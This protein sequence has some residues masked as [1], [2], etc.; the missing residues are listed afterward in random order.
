MSSLFG[1]TP[2]ANAEHRKRQTL[3]QPAQ[4]SEYLIPGRCPLRIVFAAGKNA[5]PYPPLAP[6]RLHR[7]DQSLYRFAGR[8]RHKRKAYGTVS[9]HSEACQ[10]PTAAAACFLTSSE[11]KGCENDSQLLILHSTQVLPPPLA[12]C[13]FS[14]KTESYPNLNV[15]LIK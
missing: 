4:C 14:R 1:A 15:N 7:S 2:T 10:H 13:I 9:D 12:T 8:I 3:H 5:Y 6:K 11:E